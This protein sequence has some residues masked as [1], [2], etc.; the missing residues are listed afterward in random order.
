MQVQPKILE[1][2]AKSFDA[3]F[4]SRAVP[5]LFTAYFHYAF[6]RAV[7]FVLPMIL[8]HKVPLFCSQW[9][10]HVELKPL[11]HFDFHTW[12]QYEGV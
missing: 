8:R 9:R 10:H 1:N 3:G 4:A 6:L 12:Q 5:I 7:F 2:L 11:P